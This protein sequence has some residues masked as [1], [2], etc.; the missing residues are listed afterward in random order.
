MFSGNRSR[1]QQTP[2]TARGP[3]VGEFLLDDNPRSVTKMDSTVREVVEKFS[4]GIY[5]QVVLDA[6]RRV[7]GIITKSDFYRVEHAFKNDPQ[8]PVSKVMTPN[9]YCASANDL[10]E[11]VLRTMEDRGFKTAVPVVEPGKEPGSLGYIGLLNVAA[12]ARDLAA[13]H[14]LSSEAGADWVQRIQQNRQA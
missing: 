7:V 13:K 11:N 1:K 2:E 8:T 3:K 9:P 12:V 5:T 6:Q 10:L 14:F 4:E